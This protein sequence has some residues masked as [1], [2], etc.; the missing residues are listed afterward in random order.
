MPADL[1]PAAGH[2]RVLAVVAH[3]DDETFGLGSLLLRSAAA[4]SVTAVCCFTRGEAGSPRDGFPPAGPELGRVRE[5]ELQSAAALLGVSRVEVLG[6]GDS[7]MDGDLP[8]GCLA[9]TAPDEVAARVLGV[10]RDFGA[11]VLLTID[12]GDGHR[13]HLAVRAGTE[14]AAAELGLAL[15]LQCLPRE[16]MR[17]WARVGRSLTRR[18]S[19]S[20]S[21]SS[22]LPRTSSTCSSTRASTWRSASGPSP[23]TPRS[24]RR[25]RCCRPTC[26]RPSSPGSRWS[27]DRLP[28]VPG[29]SRG[30]A[31]PGTV[32]PWP[33]T[34]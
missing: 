32:W 11:D 12:G 16:L 6:Y 20:P 2:H 22:A 33:P 26:A 7:G 24:T 21:A 9:A 3:P 15:Y 8:A 28:S 1:T 30:R 17:R 29:P 25:S 31:E 19:T 4:G 14:T 34:R 23:R 18:T 10:A 5:E 13:D 27:C